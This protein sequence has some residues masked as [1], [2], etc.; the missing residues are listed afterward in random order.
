M[1]VD[2]ETF[3]SEREDRPEFSAVILPFVGRSPGDD[4]ERDAIHR[5]GGVDG[6]LEREL[7]PV[8]EF[9][10]NGADRRLPHQHWQWRHAV[11][12]ERSAVLLEGAKR[13]AR[14]IQV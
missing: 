3:N 10:V 9:V 1:R 5:A 7:A 14:I 13:S 12:A 11:G 6:L 8:V 4:V 2:L